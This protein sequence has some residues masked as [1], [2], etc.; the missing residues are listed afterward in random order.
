MPQTLSLLELELAIDDQVYE[1][2][3]DSLLLAEHAQATPGQRCL[4][5]CT[6]T[7]LVALVLARQGAHVVATDVNPAACRLAEANAAANEL[8]MDVVL[9]DLAD[10]IHAS[11]D[12]VTC[13]PPYLPTGPDERVRGIVNRALD[14]GPDGSQVTQR[15]LDALPR[16]LA[17]EG[18]AL[19][20]VSTLQPTG[21][22]SDHARKQGLAWEPVDEVSFG[23]ERLQ[24]IELRR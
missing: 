6:G 13:N 3:E 20:V 18:R 1:P 8:A 22:L 2:A 15:V 9:T 17:S 21:A 19:L 11:F 14:G 5:L 7:G 23:M 10:G 24:L 4:D 12:L 16:L